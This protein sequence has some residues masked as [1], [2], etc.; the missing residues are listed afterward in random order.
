M[1]RFVDLPGKAFRFARKRTKKSGLF[2]W[3][4]VEPWV[5]KRLEPWRVKYAAWRIA[6]ARRRSCATF[7]AVT[8]SSGKTTTAVL[9]SHIL[10]SVA[11]VREQVLRNVYS[12]HLGSLKNSLPGDG[13][14][15]AEIGSDG[16][17]SLQPMIDLIRPSVGVVT[18]VALEHKSAF[19]NIEGVAE[20]KGR[21]VEGLPANGL[22]ILNYDDPRVVAM[23]EHATAR[24]VAFGQTGGEYVVSNV[25]CPA[26]EKL[27]LTITNE[28]NAFEIAS[29]LTGVYQ[30]VVVAA[31][32]ACT[33]Q[34][35][36]PPG[37][38]VERIASFPAVF[39]RCSVHRVPN[40]P[41]FIV[42][43]T[44]APYHS[45]RLAFDMLAEFSAPRK[46]IVVG[47]I[48]DA[49]GSDRI[50]RDAYRA[51]RSVADQV[52]FLGEHSHRTKATAEEIADGRFVRFEKLEDLADF[53]KESAIEDE[54]IL[55]KS[56]AKMHFERLMLSFFTSVRCWKLVCG[57]KDSCVPLFD[58]G[59]GLYEAPFEQHKALRKGLAYPMPAVHF[60]QND[61]ASG[62]AEN[63]APT[64]RL[65]AVAG[66]S[67]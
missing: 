52:I 61:V 10:S 8:G 54:I 40:G 33:H 7:I 62:P 55:L 21:L 20:E 25:R 2:I 1:Q 43:T 49:A 3:K 42:D 37:V 64:V 15:V 41:L 56:S 23:A 51:A 29:R 50:Y 6:Y 65:R 19:R 16:P 44:K 27:S 12:F 48:S 13:Y 66:R 57:R 45:V 34:L 11:P 4:R 38:I 31:A 67:T 63:A 18:L 36:V 30:S 58:T 35:G 17:G 60:G 59:C 26:P 46:R 28:D 14:F 24:T 39:G 53:L 32:F 9:I 5:W 22:A 47:H